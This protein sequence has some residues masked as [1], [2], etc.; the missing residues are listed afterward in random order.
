[1]QGLRAGRSLRLVKRGGM[2]IIFL[3][4]FAKGKEKAR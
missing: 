2:V 3:V 1:M 4:F